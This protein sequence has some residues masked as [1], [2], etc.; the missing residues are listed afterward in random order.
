MLVFNKKQKR[1]IFENEK[2][3]RCLR[4]CLYTGHYGSRN[5]IYSIAVHKRSS[6]FP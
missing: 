5:E 2:Q 3:N 6:I 1:S 4:R